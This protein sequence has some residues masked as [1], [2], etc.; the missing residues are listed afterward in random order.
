MSSIWVRDATE[1]DAPCLI[2]F[3]LAE[4][5][6]AEG[7]T[8]DAGTVTA[9][10]TAA[11]RE[12]A[13]ARYWLI[14]EGTAVLGAIAAVR[15]WSDWQNAAYWWIQLAFLV[16]EARGR[17]LLARLVQ[18]VLQTASAAGAPE[19]RLYVHPDNARAI[20]A[21][22]RLGFATSGYRVMS[23]PVPRRTDASADASATLDDAALWH[24]FQDRT[25]PAAQ[26]THAA[27]LRIAWMHLARHALDEAHLLMR[28]GIIRLNA[29]QGLVETPQ[30]GY[31]ETLT[32]VWLVLVGAARRRGLGADSTSVLDQPGLDRAAPLAFY[33]RE[34]L[35]SVEAR[36]IF[37]PPD[38]A[39]LP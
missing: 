17:G 13:L 31:H 7:R 28:V 14:G 12:P 10:V 37:V 35:F 34:R 23:Q 29:A 25:L 33:R 16:P 3:V 15:E 22:E 39:P 6:E 24:A 26:W 30:R 11:L 5:R 1:R 8:L 36:T 4:A 21:Y 19:L 9:S 32:R 20:R 27:H 18:H 2:E 38:L